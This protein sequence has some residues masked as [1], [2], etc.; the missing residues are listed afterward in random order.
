ML[1]TFSPIL[2]S[3]RKVCCAL[4]ETRRGFHLVISAAP[5]REKFDPYSQTDRASIVTIQVHYIIGLFFRRVLYSTVDFTRATWSR[6]SQMAMVL[7][8]DQSYWRH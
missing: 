4:D 6:N 2:Y 1:D 3:L 7:S 8:R 5:I